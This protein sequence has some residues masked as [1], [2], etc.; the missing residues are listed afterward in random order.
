MEIIASALLVLVVYFY[1]DNHSKIKKLE[2]RIEELES[3]FTND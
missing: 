3:K 1:F 2:K